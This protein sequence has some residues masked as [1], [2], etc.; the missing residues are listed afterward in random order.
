MK[1][2]SKSGVGFFYGALP[3]LYRKLWSSVVMLTFHLLSDPASKRTRYFITPL[4]SSG[5]RGLK[6]VLARFNATNFWV[7]NFSFLK[8]H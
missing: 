8:A 1:T 5:N 2:Y 4:R 3:T 6:W 7:V